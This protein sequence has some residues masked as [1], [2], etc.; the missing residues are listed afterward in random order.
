MGQQKIQLGEVNWN[1]YYLVP[2]FYIQ[3]L[4]P[5]ASKN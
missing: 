1:Y 2:A 5:L 4:I 3:H